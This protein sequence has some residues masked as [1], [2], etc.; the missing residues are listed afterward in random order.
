MLVAMDVPHAEGTAMD[1]LLYRPEEAAALLGVGRSRIYQLL[2]E[3]AIGSIQIGRSRR[4]PADALTAYV[5][6]LERKD[7]SF[8]APR[9]DRP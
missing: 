4:V 1:R 9:G 7:G 6:Q 8:I 5:N 2:A 3:G